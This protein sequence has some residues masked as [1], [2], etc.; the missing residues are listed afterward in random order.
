MKHFCLILVA[1]LTTFSASAQTAATRHGHSAVSTQNVESRQSLH[2]QM[3]RVDVSPKSAKTFMSSDQTD[4]IYDQPAG[5]LLHN[6]YG[7][8]Q[9][10]Y[11]FWYNP[12][13]GENDA[14]AD[15]IVVADD[16]SVYLKNPVSF[17]PEC[18]SWIKGT[19]AEGDTIAFEFP[20]KVFEEDVD[21]VHYYYSLYRMVKSDGDWVVDENRQTVKFVFRNDSIF[22]TESESMMGL[23]S[24]DGSLWTCYGDYNVIISKLADQTVAPQ[25]PSAAKQYKMSYNI[26]EETVSE[27]GVRLVVEGDDAYLSGF[28][29]NQPDAWAKGR[30]ENENIIFDGRTY[31]GVD[32]TERCHTWFMPA[33]LVTV[34]YANGYS[35]DE[36]QEAEQITL[37]RDADNDGYTSDGGFAVNIGKQSVM[38]FEQ[39]FKPQ[40]SYFVEIP[41]QPQK[42][43]FDDYQP[44][45]EVDGY[46]GM[47]FTLSKY[48]VDGN[49]LNPSK[50]FYRIYF[51]NMGTNPYTFGYP[52]YIYLTEPMTDIPYTFSDD[53]DF[54]VSDDLHTLYYYKDIE[55]FG[56]AAFYKDGDTVYP[57]TLVWLNVKNINDNIKDVTGTDSEVNS[58]TYHDLSGRQLSQPK[59]GLYIKTIRYADGT[60]VSRK[61]NLR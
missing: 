55:T 31:L 12:F 6:W 8:K 24:E 50:L 2:E 36:A 51:D 59:H 32:S 44:Y 39:F 22:K 5:E 23:C 57:S 14:D 61:V 45:N 56:V 3:Q 43:K 18:K 53:Y 34:T 9:G 4:I 21:G 20:Q 7:Y 46:G 13:T 42:P 11:N 40:L 54:R 16:G 25:N 15:D 41:G 49:Y 30:V 1:L 10:Y 33:K 47:R 28:A 52:E 19:K 27:C 17:Y 58:I 26:D 60:V 37:V 48:S 29:S 35:Y 38:A